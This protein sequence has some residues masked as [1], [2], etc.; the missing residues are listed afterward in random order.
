[1]QP[2]LPPSNQ[3]SSAPPPP[4]SAYGQPPASYGY[5]PY[6]P[7]PVQASYQPQVVMVDRMAR[8]GAYV[9]DVL[10]FLGA[11]LPGLG[12]A[13][14]QGGLENPSDSASLLVVGGL[15]LWLVWSIIWLILYRQTI[16][17]R[18]LSQRFVLSDGRPAGVIRVLLR[19][20]IVVAPIAVFF[21]GYAEAALAVLVLDAVFIFRDDQ[22]CL[23]DLIA[24]TYV[25]RG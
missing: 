6:A 12:L 16:A 17:K 24:D 25:V 4:P 13:V 5:N 18:L 22:R 15:A 14:Q 11:L 1:M 7:P 10:I 2:P 8:L 21:T 3:P 9:L 20:A 19:W 23:H